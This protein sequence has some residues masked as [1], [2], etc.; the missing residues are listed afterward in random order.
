MKKKP[1]AGKPKTKIP[2]KS[3]DYGDLWF[4][5]QEDLDAFDSLM[6]K[7]IYYQNS[8]GAQGEKDF[9]I[10]GTKASFGIFTKEFKERVF[11]NSDLLNKQ[12]KYL[13]DLSHSEKVASL[14]NARYHSSTDY[15]YTYQGVKS[16]GKVA[17]MWLILR[18]LPL[19]NF[20]ARSAVTFFFF[21]YLAHQNWKNFPGISNLPEERPLFYPN[22]Q[23]LDL[24]SNYPLL[25]DLVTGKR[26]TK[27]L[28]PGF[29]E[30]EIWN[31][32]QFQPYYLHHFKH[33]RYV[34]RNRRVVPWDGTFNQPIYPYF[35]LNS[36]TE[37][38]HNGLAE[39][40]E[41]KPNS[42]W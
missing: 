28:N 14:K 29:M 7:K 35:G 8:F 41:P 5:N 2:L 42:N 12:L 39:A 17:A 23:D 3:E 37:L 6:R 19:K 26:V 25:E 24:F 40:S 30:A 1:Q 27:V 18:E 31:I 32:N 21:W 16:F 15:D 13:E 34:F 4:D 9:I 22:K 33:Y 11:K 20:Y 10:D 38:V 36:R